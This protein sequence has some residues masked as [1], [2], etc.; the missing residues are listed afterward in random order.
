MVGRY[1]NKFVFFDTNMIMSFGQQTFGNTMFVIDDTGHFLFWLDKL[2]VD[3]MAFDQK[4][5]NQFGFLFLFRNHFTDRHFTNLALI[6][7]L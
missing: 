5:T 1:L 4:M 6:D 2:S 7:Q 3:Q